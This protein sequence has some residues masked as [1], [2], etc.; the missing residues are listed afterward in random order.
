[1]L[2]GSCQ[3]R[4]HSPV[5][6][7]TEARVAVDFVH[8][9]G[10]VP[11][12]VV[13]AVI[14]VLTAVV[15][16]VTWCTLTPG[17]RPGAGGSQSLT[18]EPV[19]SGA[20]CGQRTQGPG[21]YGTTRRSNSAPERKL[22]PSPSRDPFLVQEGSLVWASVWGQVLG[23]EVGHPTF[24]DLRRGSC[25]G[26]PTMTTDSTS[27]AKLQPLSTC[28]AALQ[29]KALNRRAQLALFS[30]LPNSTGPASWPSPPES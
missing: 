1:M 20:M 26:G 3:P 9:L 15:T 5:A 16:C 4:G 13:P 7:R 28:P 30:S 6:L 29:N 11:A 21:V 27:K 14:L 19:G 17:R 22:P 2:G 18:Q 10:P 12:A 25:H 23:W 24:S 8:T